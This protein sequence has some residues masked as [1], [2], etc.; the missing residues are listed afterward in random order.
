MELKV[1]YMIRPHGSVLVRL[2]ARFQASV[3]AAAEPGSRLIMSGGV[4][5]R[6]S[7]KQ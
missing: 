1:W 7:A 2:R 4:N 5:P 6:S 3:A